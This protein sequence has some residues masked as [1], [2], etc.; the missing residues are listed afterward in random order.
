[1]LIR[2]FILIIVSMGSLVIAQERSLSVT[3][4][5]LSTLR[6][7]NRLWA[8]RCDFTPT[9]VNTWTSK[10][11]A[12]DADLCSSGGGG[13]S[14]GGSGVGDSVLFSSILCYSGEQWACESVQRSMD[15]QGGMWRAPQ[16]IHNPSVSYG[17]DR[18]SYDHALG[19]LLYITTLHK[20][21]QDQK[22]YFAH[23]WVAWADNHRAN[24]INRAVGL[25][26]HGL[27]EELDNCGLTGPFAFRM[28]LIER[29]FKSEVQ[30]LEVFQ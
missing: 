20:R 1:M 11:G 6:D 24:N 14:G 21:G 8:A 30:H 10:N 16:R 12:E 5:D 27:F 29:R 25:C 9:K 7:K 4:A 22:H 3:D 15:D 18:F 26:R 23:A 17:R 28:A 13:Q 2:I 19:T